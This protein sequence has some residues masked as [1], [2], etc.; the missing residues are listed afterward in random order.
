MP[1]ARYPSLNLPYAIFVVAAGITSAAFLAYVGLYSSAEPSV[2]LVFLV[3]AFVAGFGSVFVVYR[4]SQIR[5]T[6]SGI[7]SGL[8]EIQW[9]EVID[10]STRG[11]GLHIRSKDRKIILAPWAYSDPNELM[12]FIQRA[13]DNAA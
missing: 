3:V 1:S 9:R 13:I 7:S 11:Y 4:A 8:S 12:N 2:S 5:V 10:V 6:E